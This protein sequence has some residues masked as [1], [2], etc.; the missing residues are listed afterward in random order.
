[1]TN[2]RTKVKRAA[3]START[4]MEWLPYWEN[5]LGARGVRPRTVHN[6]RE[7]LKR[8]RYGRAEKQARAIDAYQRMGS[9]VYRAA[10]SR[11]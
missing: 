2:R 8:L 11:K 10:T 7:G 1:M 9:P 5:E 3:P 6:Q 4:F